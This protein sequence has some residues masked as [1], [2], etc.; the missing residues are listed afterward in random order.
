MFVKNFGQNHSHHLVSTRT[1]CTYLKTSHA[2][3]QQHGGLEMTCV[4]YILLQLLMVA[5]GAGH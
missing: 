5:E 3:K 4:V 2:C 1:S